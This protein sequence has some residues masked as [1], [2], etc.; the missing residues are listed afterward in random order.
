[1]PSQLPLPSPFTLRPHCD[2]HPGVV[3]M[4]WARRSTEQVQAEQMEKERE[5]TAQA[6]SHKMTITKAAQMEANMRQTYED[7]CR[8]AHNPPPVATACVPHPRLPSISSEELK[9]DQKDKEQRQ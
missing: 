3:D 2:T 6:Q 1:M 9:Y 8:H 4:P 5:K 7:K